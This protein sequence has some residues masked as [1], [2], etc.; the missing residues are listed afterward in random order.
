MLKLIAGAVWFNSSVFTASRL[1]MQYFTRVEEKKERER[2]HAWGVNRI[3]WEQVL[4][5]CCS[6]YCG[7]PA[8][9]IFRWNISIQSKVQSVTRKINYSMGCKWKV[10][11]KVNLIAAKRNLCHLFH[12]YFVSNIYP[13]RKIKWIVLDHLQVH[14]DVNQI[15]RDSILMCILLFLLLRLPLLLS[16]FFS[17]AGVPLEAF[18]TIFTCTKIF[19]NVWMMRWN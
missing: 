10:F 2:K 17:L 18:V 9:H 4:S 6:N 14:S 5:M 1:E 13:V 7:R 15:N 3:Q 19:I 11:K 8:C 16:F 12:V